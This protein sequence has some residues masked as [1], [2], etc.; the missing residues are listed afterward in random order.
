MTNCEVT[1]QID[2]ASVGNAAT[3]QEYRAKWRCVN[4]T[5]RVNPDHWTAVAASAQRRGGTIHPSSMATHRKMNIGLL[6]L[7]GSLCKSCATTSSRVSLK[8]T[9]YFPTDGREP[10]GGRTHRH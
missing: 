4:E 2:A 6:T 3:V 7:D 10:Y 9:S 8:I 5:K 1:A